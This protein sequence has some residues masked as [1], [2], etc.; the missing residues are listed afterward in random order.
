MLCFDNFLSLKKDLYLTQGKWKNFAIFSI[1]CFV[2][3][4]F[5]SKGPTTPVVTT[6]TTEAD[7]HTSNSPTTIGSLEMEDCEK[8]KTEQN[9]TQNALQ[10]MLNAECSESR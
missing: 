4:F 1:S 6:T 7:I 8:Y 9:S 5:L 3:F 2:S 10:T